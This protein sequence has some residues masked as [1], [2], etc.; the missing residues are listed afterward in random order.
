MGSRPWREEGRVYKR[1]PTTQERAKFEDVLDQE[2][3]L[4]MIFEGLGVHRHRGVFE[5]N[6]G[7]FSKLFKGRTVLIKSQIF[8]RGGGSTYVEADIGLKGKTQCFSVV[9]TA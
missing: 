9:E 2:V 4:I 3:Y 5:C 8:R 1:V 6:L 7:I